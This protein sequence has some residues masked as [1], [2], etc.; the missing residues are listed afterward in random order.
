MT[1]DIQNTS[2]PREKTT[3]KING[4]KAA[5]VYFIV[6][7]K[8][9]NWQENS[10]FANEINK[11]LEEMYPGVSGGIIEKKS[12]KGWNQDLH[13]QSLIINIGGK[14]NTFNEAYRTADM[15]ANVVAELQK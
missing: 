9:P 12:I 3:I 4:Q 5:K 2:L 11:T 15:L 10:D 14:G 8:N 13:S 6:D 7:Q 1:F